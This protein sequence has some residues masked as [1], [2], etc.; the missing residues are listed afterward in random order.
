MTAP[1]IKGVVFDKDGTLFDFQETWGAWARTVLIDESAG[2]AGTLAA[3]S[4]TLGYDMDTGTFQRSS[5]VIAS[6]A[7]EIAQAALPHLAETS[8]DALLKRWNAAAAQAP[9]IEAT[10]LVAFLTQMQSA[11][12]ALGVAT[13]DGEAPARA[14]LEAA[15]TMPF[16]DFVA[17]SDSGHGGKPAPGQLLAF[18]DLTG[19]RPDVCA[20][21][22]DSTHD[23]HAGR[24][25]GMTCVAV[26]TGIATRADLAPHADVVLDSIADLPA[27]LGI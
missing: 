20:M 17:G 22:G 25:A 7:R 3:L 27:W 15:Q 16:W 1:P 8:V 14:H 24:A 2:D 9:Q 5:I 4:H 11:G 6:T 23:L 18:C 21:V 10:P 13:N 12:I 19:L 26:L